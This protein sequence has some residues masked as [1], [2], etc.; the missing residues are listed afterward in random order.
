[1][2]ATSGKRSRKR[3]TF[4]R[5]TRSE[6]VVAVQT[7]G[8][9]ML[10]SAAQHERHQSVEGLRMVALERLDADVVQVIADL[11]AR[12]ALL[13]RQ[14]HDLPHAW[15]HGINRRA[16]LAAREHPRRAVRPQ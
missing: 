7:R 12:P 9:I 8:A 3:R 14:A 4:T 10:P 1:M 6:R 13:H 5:K 16:E 2:M 15:A 11:L